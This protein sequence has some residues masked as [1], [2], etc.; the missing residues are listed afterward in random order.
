ME[1]EDFRAI[2][3]QFATGVTVIT[4]THNSKPYGFT[5]KCGSLWFVVIWIYNK[6]WF[7][8]VCSN[9]DL[10][11]WFAVIWI[12]SNMWFPFGL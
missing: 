8:L 4:T 7:P 10:Q 2:C 6:M 3:A 11:L 12:Y 9:M 5:A 1:Q